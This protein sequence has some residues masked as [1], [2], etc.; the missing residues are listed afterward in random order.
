MDGLLEAKSE[1]KWK[2]VLL[3]SARGVKAVG[4]VGC[5]CVWGGFGVC[6]RYR[7][8]VFAPDSMRPVELHCPARATTTVT[9][10][11]DICY[12]EH[13]WSC[14]ICNVNASDRFSVLSPPPGFDSRPPCPSARMQSQTAVGL[15]ERGGV[16]GWEVWGEG[17]GPWPLPFSV[18]SAYWSVQSMAQLSTMFNSAKIPFS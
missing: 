10:K 12:P 16:E 2:F 15:G 4:L 7:P 14:D 6:M 11:V 3:S 17:E 9:L 18:Y 13:T 5:V 1:P 8:S